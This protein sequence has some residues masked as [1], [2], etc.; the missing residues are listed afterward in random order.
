MPH[1]EWKLDGPRWR[2]LIWARE[3]GYRFTGDPHALRTF[4]LRALGVK[5]VEGRRLLSATVGPH[6]KLHP[7]E[8]FVQ[9]LLN[10]LMAMESAL[11]MLVTSPPPPE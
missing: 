2:P 5:L 7:R 6:A 8:R 4:E 3:D 10:Q 11:D 1:G 9:Y